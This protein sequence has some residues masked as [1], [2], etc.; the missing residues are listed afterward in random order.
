MVRYEGQST[1]HTL[2]TTS[3]N[4]AELGV[5]FTVQEWPG[6]GFTRYVLVETPRLI[7]LDRG[8]PGEARVYL[9]QQLVTLRYRP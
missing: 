2:R 5:G 3:R 4:R 8:T 7:H 6:S 1:S 9:E